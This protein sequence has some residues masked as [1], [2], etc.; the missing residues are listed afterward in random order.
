MCTE[1]RVSKQIELNQTDQMRLNTKALSPKGLANFSVLTFM[2][3]ASQTFW[4]LL[5]MEYQMYR[6]RYRHTTASNKT[7]ILYRCGHNTE[8]QKG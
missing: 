8:I 7:K 5:W 2:P 6:E 4:V 1:E 3:S